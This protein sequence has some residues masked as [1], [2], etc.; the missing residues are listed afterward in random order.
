MTDWGL[1]DKAFWDVC[2]EKIDFEKHARYVMEKVFNNGCWNDQVAV[3][4][5]YGLQKIKKE[6]VQI[7]YLRP[8]VISFLSA[9]LKVPKDEFRCCILKPSLQMPWNY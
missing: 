8:T 7:P 1:S 6:V 4:N 5:Y 3:M 9:L 2:F